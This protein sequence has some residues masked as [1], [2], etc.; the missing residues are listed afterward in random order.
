MAELVQTKVALHLSQQLALEILL[1]CLWKGKLDSSSSKFNI[2]VD[3][4]LTEINSVL[5]YIMTLL[6]KSS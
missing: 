6:F 1:T 4:C 3:G 5:K 2:A